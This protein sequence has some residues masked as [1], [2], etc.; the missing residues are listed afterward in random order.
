[1]LS[2]LKSAKFRLFI[3]PLLLSVILIVTYSSQ[4]KTIPVSN[5]DEI[6]WIG[7]S[8]F[9]DFYIRGDFKNK[10]WGSLAYDQPNL[11]KYAY[12][13]WLYPLYLNEKHKNE[14]SFDFIR[15]LM[16]NGFYEID[17]DYKKI[18][19]GYKEISDVVKFN[20][21]D[22]GTPKYY[23]AKYGIKSLK[24]LTLI[25]YARILDILLLT[26][27]VILAYFIAL[28]YFGIIT[29]II[30]SFFYGFNYLVVHF[31]LKAQT[32]SLF[33]FTFNA[34]FLFMSLYFFKG[35]KISY[36][37]L[38]SLFSGLC[39]ST[40]L[41]GIMFIFIFLICNLLLFFI[42]KGK[43]SLDIFHG[44]VPILICL[45]IFISLNPFT[46]PNPIKNI[47]SMFNYRM[48]TALK[49]AGLKPIY[50]LPDGKSR[51]KKIFEHF[52]LSEKSHYFN[53]TLL[54]YKLSQSNNYRISL[55]IL[56]ILG[57]FYSIKLA[58]KKNLA[59]IIF[60]CSF[61]TIIAIMSCYLILDFKRYYIHL[62]LF[63][64]LYQSL[65][66]Y[67]LLKILLRM[68]GSVFQSDKN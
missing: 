68:F 44:I 50:F 31:G 23:V 19:A 52:Y 35:R 51:V 27:A 39:M 56:F 34:A 46:F 9:F 16:K 30:F 8:Y 17:K 37:L 5:W 36:L 59:A 24:P 55:I 21:Y 58:F 15:F 42:F 14:K 54:S 40:K 10:I 63:F 66:I 3:V 18:Y 53:D 22:E 61:F 43:K 38:F 2:L 47:K 33:L 65:G 45:I 6:S 57:L 20:N 26:A 11:T 13:A 67:L 64:V 60:L 1:M 7:S 49:D 28:K 62:V 32:E 25:Y 48:H 29:A 41:N 12:G 4:I